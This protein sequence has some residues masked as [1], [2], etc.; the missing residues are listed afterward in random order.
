MF[1][2]TSLYYQAFDGGVI[3]ISVYAQ[4]F[5]QLLE[6]A[7]V[8]IQLLILSAILGFLL[9]FLGGIG[10]L[11]RIDPIRWISG[12][13]VEFLR[14]TS[15]LVQLFWLFYALP[16][17]G[18]KLA[19]GLAGI[20]AL[21]LN[22]GAYGSEVVR[23]A[24]QS[25]PKGQTEAAIALNMTPRQ[26]MWHVILPQAFRT[27]L[28]SFG[29]LFI[30]LLKGTALVSLITI[31]DMTFEASAMRTNIEANTPEIFTLLLLMYFVIGYPL[32]LATRWLERRFSVG[33]L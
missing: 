12:F 10:R 23:G 31:P 30:E 11:S 5:P 21:S 14:G 9:S 6:G 15:L 24:I 17:L 1:L 26:Q 4:I 13:F 16:L 25:I 7:F 33:R 27:M 32:T 22:Y 29:N 18:I 8:T 20:L 19:P 3:P 28:P 2:R